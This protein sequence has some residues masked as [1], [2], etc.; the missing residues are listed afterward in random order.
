M[1]YIKV[2][3]NLTT[4]IFLIIQSPS[5]PAG[6]KNKNNGRWIKVISITDMR[7]I[8]VGMKLVFGLLEDPDCELK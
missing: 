3:D 7:L 4:K 5:I 2:N 8:A 6:D 1:K